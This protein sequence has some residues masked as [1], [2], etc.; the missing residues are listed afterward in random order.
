[1]HHAFI[2]IYNHSLNRSVHHEDEEVAEEEEDDDDDDMKRVH[3][4]KP[5]S[6][7]YY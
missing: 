1:M 7:K 5:R 6:S 4:L 2:P 3:E